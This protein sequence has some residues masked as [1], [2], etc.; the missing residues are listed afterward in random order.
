MKKLFFFIAAASLLTLQQAQAQF[1]NNVVIAHRGAWKEAGL[2]ENSIASLKHAVALGCHASEFDVHLTKDN[3]IVVN[4][5]DDFYGMDIEN[6]TY[7]ELLTIKHPNGESIPTLE[8]YLTEG[9]KQ[10]G[11]KLILEVKTS[12]KGKERTLQLTKMSVELVKKLK[13]KNWVEYISFDYDACKL[14]HE[15]NSKAKVAYLTG[16]IAPAQVKKDGLTGLD[17]HYSVY[18]KN[19]SWIA[20]AKQL[21]LTINAWT[22]NETAEMQQLIDQKVEYI[23]TNEPELLFTLLKK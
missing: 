21:G 19:P 11:T 12:T 4:H 10:K 9:I 18:Q 22:V 20:E 5:N 15:L 1:N 3:V 6:A 2:P 16:D 13:A 23:T 14:V 8:D 17:Y 7:K